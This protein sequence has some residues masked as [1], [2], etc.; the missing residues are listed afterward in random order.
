M[1]G[2]VF[3]A[4]CLDLPIRRESEGEREGGGRERER[5]DGSEEEKEVNRYDKTG[6]RYN[7]L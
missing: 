3:S 1:Y 5:G 4:Q 2:N 7:L 6:K